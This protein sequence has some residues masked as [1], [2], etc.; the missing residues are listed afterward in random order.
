MWAHT[1]IQEKILT[2]IDQPIPKSQ[3]GAAIPDCIKGGRDPRIGNP[4]WNTKRTIC[5][6]VTWNQMEEISWL[7]FLA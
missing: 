2:T 4:P 3:L 7:T 6:G 1:Y 5:S